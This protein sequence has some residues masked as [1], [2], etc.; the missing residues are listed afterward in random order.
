MITGLTG[1]NTT[2]PGAWV[3]MGLVFS[4]AGLVGLRGID[5]SRPVGLER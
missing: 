2:D 4:A 1:V 5:W 3:A